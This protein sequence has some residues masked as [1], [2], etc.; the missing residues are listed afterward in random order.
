[1][2]NVLYITVTGL[3]IQAR[4]NLAFG[5]TNAQRQTKFHFLEEL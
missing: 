1:M 3:K 4:H 2:H 5:R